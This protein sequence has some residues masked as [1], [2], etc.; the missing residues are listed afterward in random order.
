MGI[1]CKV[2]VLFRRPDTRRGLGAVSLTAIEGFRG[3]TTRVHLILCYRTFRGGGLPGLFVNIP[4]VVRK[5]V[6]VQWRERRCSRHYIRGF[7]SLH[8][9]LV[10]LF[11]VEKRTIEPARSAGRKLFEGLGVPSMGAQKQDLSRD[12]EPHDTH[13]V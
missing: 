3:Q 8:L 6:F 9:V 12:N 10:A 4:S 11:R 7:F 2:G 5:E 1:C 13:R